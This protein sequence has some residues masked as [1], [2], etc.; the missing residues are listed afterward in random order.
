MLARVRDRLSY[1]NVVATLALFVALGGS[2]YAALSITSKDVQN[3]SL[4][5]GDLRKNTVTGTEINESKLKQVPAARVADTAATA[6]VSK[7]AGT[8]TT[9]GSATTAAL[10]DAAKDAQNLAGQGVGAFEKS[11]RTSFGKAPS[12]PA[13]PSNEQ[14]LLSWPEM[15]V[16]LTTASGGGACG[17][18]DVRLGLRNT[19]ASGPTAFLFQQGEVNAIGTAPAGNTVRSCTL[20]GSGQVTDSTGL[21][22]FFDCRDLNGELRCLGVRSQ[23]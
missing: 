1:A 5:G 10:A 11:S 16:E 9:A 22:L 17:A 19:K 7:S 8:A 13:G 21:T 15:G 6:D 4:K 14:V 12:G 2:S 18:D 23:P 3:R 20:V